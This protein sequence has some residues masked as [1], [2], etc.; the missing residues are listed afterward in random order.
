M[1]CTKRSCEQ[2]CFYCDEPL[3]GRRHEHDH[4]PPQRLGGTEAVSACMEC[5]TLK[6]RTPL[7][8]WPVSMQVAALKECGPLGRI[9]LAKA[10]ATGGDLHA[11]CSP[12]A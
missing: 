3:F 5:H 4:I 1:S 9:Y 7:T 6:D 11:D 10:F 8:Q 12:V 2:I